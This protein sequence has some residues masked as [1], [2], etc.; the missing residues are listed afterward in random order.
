MAKPKDKYRNRIQEVR[1]LRAGELLDHEGNWRIHPQFQLEATEG[2]LTDVG[3]VDVLKAYYSERNGGALTLLDGHGR[4]SINPDEEWTVA[5]LDLTD[6]E[7]DMQ[8]ALHDS[9]GAW[10]QTDAMKL[11]ALIEQ[12][13]ERHNSEKAQEALSRLANSISAQVELA[14]RMAGDEEV[15]KPARLVEDFEEGMKRKVRVVIPIEEGLELV[16]GAIRMTGI[17]NRGDAMIAI[18][19]YFLDHADPDGDYTVR[20][21]DE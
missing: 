10:A 1:I 5:I 20:G 4:K 17:R 18:C 3:K 14:R 7:A 2:S 6:A 9:I 8:L 15:R 12:A 13:R 11:N 16:E 19:R 21:G